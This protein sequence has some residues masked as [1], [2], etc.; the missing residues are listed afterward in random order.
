MPLRPLN[1]PRLPFSSVPCEQWLH[2]QIE[3]W[4]WKRLGTGMHRCLCVGS[5]RTKQNGRSRGERIRRHHQNEAEKAENRGTPDAWKCFRNITQ[6]KK[7][8]KKW[9][10][11][12]TS[13]TRQRGHS[14]E[15]SPNTCFLISAFWSKSF[16][17][18]PVNPHYLLIISGAYSHT[19]FLDTP[20]GWANYLLF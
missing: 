16:C 6:L 20:L 1:I 9:F 13:L 2:L 7:V 12:V 19:G 3:S 4:K 8:P 17:C 11:W 10:T 15:T 5:S 18:F 14:P